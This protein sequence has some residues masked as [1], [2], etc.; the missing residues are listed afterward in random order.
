[1]FPTQ[2]PTRRGLLAGA[3]A[4]AAAFLLPASPASAS[5]RTAPVPV[6][7]ATLPNGFGPEGIAI[8]RR[9]IAYCGGR[10]TGAIQR[11]DLATGE[12]T[13]LVAGSDAMALGLKVDA[14]GRLF[15]AGSEG[16]DARVVDTRTGELLAAYRLFTA[17][18]TGIVNDL[19][20]TREA[21]YLTD[22]RHPVLYVLPL[23][24]GGAL[25]AQ[26][27]VF[28][29]PLT[30]FPTSTEG[31]GINA[32]GIV[33][34]PDGT[35]LLVMHSSSEL[36]YRVDPRTGATSVVDLGGEFPLPG[37]GLLRI[38][39]TL[40]VVCNL[41]NEV[42]VVTLD[43]TGRTGTVTARITDPSFDV[44]T[45]VA[46]YRG[47]LYLPNARFALPVEPTTTYDVVSVPIP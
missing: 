29:L 30:D 5:A 43:R 40:Y 46:A 44:P 34:T 32:N 9:G 27:Q 41:A 22:S 47:R 12:G 15:V 45:T 38:G 26:S 31:V 25:P 19:V 4:T 33:S 3:A 42:A 8:D 6:T 20:I 24:P 37:D 13:Q 11:I 36:L 2:Q 17:P 10:L 21:V 39:H 28:T 16:G 7:T 18:S 23:G 1:M 35:A 14:Y